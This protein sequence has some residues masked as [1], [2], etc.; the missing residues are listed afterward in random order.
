MIT[1]LKEKYFLKLGQM[2][3]DFTNGVKAYWS[4]LNKIINRNEVTNIPPLL[5]NG[6]FV[7]NY[8]TKADVFNEF[9]AKQCSLLPNDSSIPAF[10]AKCDKILPSVGIDRSK[11]LSLIRSLDS[12]KAHGCADLSIAKLKICDLAIVEPLSLIYEKCLESGKYSSLWKKANV[13]P[14]HKKESR[15]LKKNYRPISML[16]ICG[17]LFEKLIFDEIYDHLVLPICG[18][19]FEKLIFD[20]IYDHLVKNDLLTPNQSGFRPGD[21]TINQLLSITY[22]IYTAFEE[23]PSKDTRAVFLDISKAFDK[24]WHEGL[25]FELECDGLSG[26]LLVMIRSYLSYRVQRVVSN[27]KMSKWTSVTAGVPKVL[28]WDLCFFSY[29]LMIW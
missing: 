26:P 10:T 20:E 2:L 19:L 13:L 18:K 27:G 24:V 11:I 28:Y 29:T 4:A 8:K 14:I 25:L 1:S 16:P 17:K 21:S 7:T 12:K 6:D 5:E 3:S 23:F 22:C 15:Q 9:F